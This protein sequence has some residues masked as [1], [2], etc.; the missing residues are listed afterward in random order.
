MLYRLEEPIY[1]YLFTT[2]PILVVIFLVVLWWKKRTQKKFA[3]SDL[4]TKLAPN[5]S[6]FKSSLK[7]LF[8]SIGISFLILALVNPKIGTKLKTV[9]RE[10]VDIVFALDVSKSMLAEDIAPNRLEKS[11]QI[12]SKIIDKLGSDRV[13][14]IIYAGNAYPLLPITTDHGAA[15][16]F[17]QNANPD[18]VSSQG[19]A[20]KEAL[21]LAK[22]YYNNDDQTNR[23]LII[24]SDGEDHQEETKQ[25]AQN[26]SNEG[27]KVYTIGVGS[28]KGAPIPMKING[29]LIGYKKYK[30]E[31]VLTKRNSD[32]L[33]G[34]A[35]V[36]NSNYIEIGRAHV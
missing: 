24:I 34:V 29:S 2:I 25:L 30:G 19:T 28:E 21:D 35:N 14:I 11:K 9:K 33:K 31:T 12:I 6:V 18:L 27:V 36:A 3:S 10:G 17:L 5:Y 23:F 8:F 26:V 4:L 16:M 7:L 13:G 20:I 32:L 1:F 15:K 22:T